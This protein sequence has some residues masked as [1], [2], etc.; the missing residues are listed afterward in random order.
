[1]SSR[2]V[3]VGSAN[4]DMVVKAER[5]PRPGETVLGGDFTLTAGGKGANQAVAAARMG[6]QV[7]FVGRVGGDTFGEGKTDA[8]YVL[9]A[10]DT[11][12]EGADRHQHDFV[13][14]LPEGPCPLGLQEADDLAADLADAQLLAQ[15]IG[16]AKQ[17][18]VN[19]RTDDADRCAR[20]ILDRV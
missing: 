11:P 19:G 13:L 15:R 7:T 5:I 4:V 2:I 20:T 1:M 16:R 14:I 12:L 17:R 3:V 6:G 18:L 10:R 9:I 8:R